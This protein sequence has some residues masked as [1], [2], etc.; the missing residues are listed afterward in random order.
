MSRYTPERL[1]AARP[2]HLSVKDVARLIGTHASSYHGYETGE[3]T[4]TA[5]RIEKVAAVFG[6]PVT[7][8]YDPTNVNDPVVQQTTRIKGELAKIGPFTPEEKDRLR[9]LLRRAVA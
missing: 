2:D 8:L 6:I 5:D 1:R 9:A 3:S 7:D 4:P